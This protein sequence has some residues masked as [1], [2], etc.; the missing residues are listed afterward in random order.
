MI[1]ASIT[2]TRMLLLVIN[3]HTKKP[4]NTAKIK[5]INKQIATLVLL[6]NFWFSITSVPPSST[7]CTSISNI[8]SIFSFIFVHVPCA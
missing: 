4:I 6:E 2:L 7:N 5:I 1:A 8:S 3:V